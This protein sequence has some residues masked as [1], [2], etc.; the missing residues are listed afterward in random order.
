MEDQARARHEI[1][2]ASDDCA[3]EPRRR[4]LTVGR[5]ASFVLRA[6]SVHHKGERAARALLIWCSIGPT[7]HRSLAIGRRPGQ[8]QYIIVELAM[9]ALAAVLTKRGNRETE[10][11][12]ES[13]DGVMSQMVYTMT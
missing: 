2:H 12:A 8:R 4:H 1:K 7:V 9:L 10:W 6:E 11:K 5:K 13:S 3:V